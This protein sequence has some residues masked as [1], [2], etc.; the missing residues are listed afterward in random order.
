[1]GHASDNGNVDG[2]MDIEDESVV[3]FYRSLDSSNKTIINN[4]AGGALMDQTF[5]FGKIFLEKAAR[6]NRAWGVWGAISTNMLE[7]WERKGEIRDKKMAAIM[8][9]PKI[10]SRQVMET[11]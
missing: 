2:F 9:L 11:K 1:M 7:E 6:Q 8:E 10:L 3:Y 5:K 4:L